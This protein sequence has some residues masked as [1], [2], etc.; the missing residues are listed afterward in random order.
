MAVGVAA[1]E[2]RGRTVKPMF[3]GFENVSPFCLDKSKLWPWVM[4]CCEAMGVAFHEKP[5]QFVVTIPVPESKTGITATVNGEG[6]LAKAR[7]DRLWRTVASMIVDQT[8]PLA[9]P[10][11]VVDS[12]NDAYWEYFHFLIWSIQRMTPIG[13]T[14]TS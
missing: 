2:A 6:M 8:K 4:A 14:S 12:A 3:D 5:F 9:L 1:Q 7:I 11:V 10:T 13:N